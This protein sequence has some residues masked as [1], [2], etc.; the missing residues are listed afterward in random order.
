MMLKTIGEFLLKN[1]GIFFGVGGW[2]GFG[3][4]LFLDHK[5]E[6]RQSQKELM[7]QIESLQAELDGY[8]SFEKIDRQLDKSK[9]MVYLEKL[10]NLTEREIC[11]NCWETKHVK[12]PVISYCDPIEKDKSAPC[13]N[14]GARLY[15]R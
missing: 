3:V 2:L 15:Y 13:S 7:K 14:C 4:K 10:D 9:G 5:K 8:K 12:I 1:W 11:G 6:K